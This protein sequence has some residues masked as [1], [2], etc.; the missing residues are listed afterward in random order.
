VSSSETWL[1]WAQKLQAIAQAG[2]AY[3]KD[4]YD[5]ERFQQLRGI[6]VNIVSNLTGASE[7][8]VRSEFALGSGYPTPKVDVRAVVFRDGNILLVR[9]RSA[10]LWSL[11]GG[12]A[13][14][15]QS[16]SEVA[17][18]E[19]L[20]ESGFKV[21]PVKLLALL[22]KAK[23]PHPP[24]LD[25]VYKLFMSCELEGGEPRVSHETDA[26][27]FFDATSL[28]QLDS[29]RVTLTQVVRMFEHHGDPSLPTDFD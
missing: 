28:P 29:R 25:Y 23:L 4:P 20:E 21:R 26:V 8:S 6:A 24:S 15:G 17:T 1:A 5:L 16:P 27:E 14:I 10:G 7:E 9:E 18:R 3:S 11:P 12:W 19:T 13:D 22:D 2:L